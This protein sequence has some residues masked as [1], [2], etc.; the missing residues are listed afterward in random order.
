M[1]YKYLFFDL[2]G[3]LTDPAEGI[4]N[5]II[6][7]LNKFN[8]E[9]NDRTS[10]YKFIGPPLVDSYMKFYGFDEKKAWTAVQYYREYFSVNGLFE[11]KVY[12]GMEKLLDTLQKQGHKLY[13]AT[14]KPKEYSV[15]ILDKFGLLKYFEYVSGSSMDEKDCDKATIIKN[16]LTVS[17]ADKK[18]VLMI[19]DRCFD[20][21]GA[22]ANG[23]D[24]LAVLYGYGSCEEIINSAP[25][26]IAKTVDD[27]FNFV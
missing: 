9:V 21:N 25:N 11:N 12:G 18:D 2:D 27:I 3:T 17:S 20:I 7:S 6:Y 22:K 10:L 4:T 14:S 26:Y 13:V 19:G 24:S 23:I 16:A 8:I 5:S 1:K 15:R